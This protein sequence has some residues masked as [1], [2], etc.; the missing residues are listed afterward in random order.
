[1]RNIHYL[2]DIIEET[3]KRNPDIDPS[4][5]PKSADFNRLFTEKL[6][7]VTVSKLSLLGITFVASNELAAAAAVAETKVSP[8]DGLRFSA[9][10]TE[11]KTK[12]HSSFELVV[13]QL[14]D[15]REF[16]QAVQPTWTAD[17]IGSKLKT[18]DTKDYVLVPSNCVGFYILSVKSG[19]NF[20]Y[21]DKRDKEPSHINQF[22]LMNVVKFNVT[23]K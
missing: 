3:L 17:R 13:W 15:G 9:T 20:T 21:E 23:G 22:N 12:N 10:L 2:S 16:I 14:N 7:D 5:P 8:G 19:Y 4:V 11:T 1:M 18:H 6:I